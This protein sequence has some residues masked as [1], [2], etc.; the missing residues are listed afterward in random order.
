VL[1]HLL[2]PTPSQKHVPELARLSLADYMKT[3]NRTEEE[4]A[5]VRRSLESRQAKDFVQ[6]NQPNALLP[7]AA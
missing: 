3:A 1:C 5:L 4:E 7:E 6:F 2:I